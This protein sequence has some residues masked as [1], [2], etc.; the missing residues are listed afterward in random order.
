MG[1]LIIS[2]LIAFV[3][4]IVGYVMGQEKKQ[5]KIEKA[6]KKVMSK[7]KE[8]GEEGPV[9]QL[10][11]NEVRETKLKDWRETYLK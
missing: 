1:E 2:A 11:P 8:E 3:F 9:K 5:E 6:V 7:P 4:L 10:S